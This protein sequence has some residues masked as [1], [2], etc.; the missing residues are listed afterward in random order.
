MPERKIYTAFVSSAFESLR[1]EREEVILCLLDHRILPIGQEHFTVT[2]FRAIQRFIDESDY[3]ILLMGNRYGSI[4]PETGLS[5]TEREYRYALEKKKPVLALVCEDLAQLR[6]ADAATLTEDQNRQVEFCNALQHFARTVTQEFTIR[7]VVSQYISATP[8]HMCPGWIR[9]QH[10]DEAKSQAW[11]EENPGLFVGGT[12]YHVHLNNKVR[13]Y[14]R[15]GTVQIHQDF[16]PNTFGQ[17][18]MNGE[19]FGVE[20]VNPDG[21]LEEDTE[22]HSAFWG[23]Y[24]LDPDGKIFGI[25]FV[26]RNFD[27]G[28]FGDQLVTEGDKRGIHDFRLPMGQE[29]PRKITGEFHDEAPSQKHGRIYLFRDRKDRDAFVLKKRP[30][31]KEGV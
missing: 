13:D 14:I 16:S 9:V 18:R 26:K 10:M 25:F 7:T 22:Q 17:L 6:K 31:L 11:R 29:Q 24:R 27:T 2:D 15:I 1:D 8:L 20:E 5:W 28:H 19:N 23:D 12:W 30:E 3:F 4:D 21:S